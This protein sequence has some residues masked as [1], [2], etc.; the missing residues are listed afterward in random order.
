MKTDELLARAAAAC[1]V[2]DF[3][4]ARPLLVEG[5][6]RGN[7]P[8]SA[9][10]R[11]SIIQRRTGKISEALA[12]IEEG[13]I[14]FPDDMYLLIE[15]MHNAAAAKEWERCFA[16]CDYLY[17][18][19]GADVPAAV[20]DSCL[21]YAVLGNRGADGVRLASRVNVLTP[22]H[23]QQALHIGVCSDSGLVGAEEHAIAKRKLYMRTLHALHT[24]TEATAADRARAFDLMLEASY[25]AS[26]KAAGS[27]TLVVMLSATSAFSLKKF[28]FGT[29]VLFL[30]DNSRT[31]FCVPL[32]RIVRMIGS[33]AESNGY[34]TVSLV[35][36]SKAAA[37]ALMIGS[38]LSEEKP[39]LEVNALAFSPQTQ[40]YPHA[41]VNDY[42]P[43]YQQMHKAIGA[44]STLSPYM[45]RHGDLRNFD[46]SRLN[47]CRVYYGSLNGADRSEA[48]R[49]GDKKGV[50]L[51]EIKSKQHYTLG[52]FTCPKDVN[53]EVAKARFAANNDPDVV[54]TRTDD[55]VEEYVRLSTA[56]RYD[57]L[58]ELGLA[59][60]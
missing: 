59:T 42:L 14:H 15:Q 52:F 56:H 36:C 33:L 44:N 43:S 30:A 5:I 29:D 20:Y 21:E 45:A 9:Y 60:S 26:L 57:L 13:L 11:L 16:S 28:E 34:Q 50:E 40:I 58:A 55:A 54:A 1:K 53:L 8:V 31:Y 49:L 18:K 4:V 39:G 10:Q 19:F 48:I 25:S 22:E 46:Y 35:G 2:G 27:K 6:S 32:T 12:L 51:V 7:A 38:L 17:A 3:E 24:D 41:A 47:R 37:G 23:W